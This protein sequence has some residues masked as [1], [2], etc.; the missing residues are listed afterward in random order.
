M[1][2]YMGE[3][4]KQRKEFMEAYK[5]G[6]YKKAIFLGRRLLDIYEENDDCRS[7][8]YA[9][10]LSNLGVVFDQMRFYEKAA[11]YYEKAAALKKECGGE[12]LSY[13]D[14][15]NN[16]AI[17]YNQT[18]RQEDALR[19]HS[20]ALE[21]RDL[22]LGRD[23]MDYIHSLYHIGNTYELMENAEKAVE[24]FEK[25]LRRARQCVDFSG[26]DLADI[27]GALAR[28]FDR[29]GNFKKAIYYYEIC[30]DLIEKERGSENYYYMMHMLTLAGVCEKAGLTDLAVEYCERAIEIRRSLMSEEHLDFINSLNNLAAIC[31]K[32]KQYEKAL[33]LHREALELVERM[34]GRSHVFYADALNNLSVDY[35]GMKEY[36]K[37]L[38]L[39]QKALAQKRLLLG[40]NDPQTA[41][42]LMSMGTLYDNMG[43]YAEAMECYQQALEIRRK[44]FSEEDSCCADT[45]TAIGRLYEHQGAYEAAAAAIQEGIAIRRACGEERSG[46]YVWSL[47]LLAEVRQ[48]QGEYAAAVALCREGVRIMEQRYGAKH[49][50]YASALEKLG[51]AYEGA[52]D[53]GG[54]AAALELAAKIR[55][56]TLDED[57]PQYLETLELL[58]R[59]LMKKKE[60]AKAIAYYQ[61]KNDVNFEET[62]QEQLSAANNLLAI[63]NCY[64]LAGNETKAEAYFAEAEGKLKR[65]GILPDETYETR[66][67]AYLSARAE[68]PRRGSQPLGLSRQQAENAVRM[69]EKL[70]EERV[71]EFGEDDKVAVRTALAL[72][73]LLH[74]IGRKEEAVQ[75][76]ALAEKEGK[77]EAYVR[78]CRW[79]GE[80]WLKKGELEQA[81]RQLANAKEYLTEYGEI[82]SEE[83]CAVL[84]LLGDY[85]FQKGEK[86]R[87]A[88]CYQPW[89][90]LYKELHLPDNAAYE[91]R[92]ERTARILA[93]LK[94]NKEA[95][96]C[97]SALALSI[98]GREG[99]TAN[100]VRLLM[101]T[102]SLHASLGN[103]K[104]TETLLDRALL[105]GAQG[106]AATAA[107]G[108]LCDRA[109]RIYVTAGCFEK[110][111][112][113]L[114]LAYRIHGGGERCMTK[115]GISALLGILRTKGDKKAYLAVKNGEALD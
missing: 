30:L 37:A 22:K 52:D 4:R 87:A 47:Q 75:W 97:Y 105:L 112:E 39:N 38:A 78:A 99:E 50:R 64:R 53:L 46:I 92:A 45:L 18:G 90:K 83:Y 66:R 91:A 88:A 29:Q 62:P 13:A 41:A 8:E 115:E 42:S 20:K 48:K 3:I 98:R 102:A 96:E 59:V 60:Y 73:D 14:T 106:G 40:D 19:L 15:L 72:G 25:A 26:M 89:N 9:S 74:R 17:V 6:D 94:R 76:F 12:C 68:K 33:R 35:C 113:A 56:E 71:R 110:A 10:D 81:F 114:R 61:E 58:A 103:K 101:K 109:G 65:S 43:K 21:I 93:E 49:P 32:D 44:A 100:F 108:R 34:L 95:V 77:G 55:K 51:I 27:H 63:A 1:A 16:L 111:E 84:G 28:G 107:Y 36:K 7:M 86:E 70:F 57:N 2:F 24:L 85:Y 79:L 104:D 80:Y 54:A 31:C 82:K 67:R 23:H 5:D 69:F 11:E